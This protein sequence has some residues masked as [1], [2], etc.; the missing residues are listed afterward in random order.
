MVMSVPKIPAGMLQCAGLDEQDKALV[1][2][3]QS[4]LPL[5]SHPYAELGRGI[6]LSETEV[7]HRLKRMLDEDYIKR[8]GVVV[9]HHELGYRANAM[10]VWDVADAQV[11]E[12]GHCMG[13]FEFITLCYQRPRRLPDWRYN[14]FCMIHGRDRD[15]VLRCVDFA[16]ERCALQDIAHEVLFS[17]R[18]FKQRGARY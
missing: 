1:S 4:G 13:Q 7:I 8:M 11:S 2:A 5:C 18:R 15:E 10:V 9:R 12:L 3:I 16:I 6:G 14:L 17:Q